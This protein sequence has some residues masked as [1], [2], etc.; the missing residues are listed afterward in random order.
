VEVWQYLLE[1]LAGRMMDDTVLTALQNKH[2]AMPGGLLFSP[3]P[4]T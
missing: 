4:L 3:W 2:F 1:Q